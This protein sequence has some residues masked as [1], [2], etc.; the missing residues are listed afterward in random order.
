MRVLA[1]IHTMNDEAVIEQ[2]LEGL[3][4]QTRPSDA[5]LIV[6][7]ASTDKTLDRT[8]SETVTIVR[9]SENLGT[10]GTIRIGLAHALK[11]GFDWTWIFDADTVPES[12]SLEKLLAFF[13]GLSTTEQERVCF[14]TGWPLTAAGE[15]KQPAMR[16]EGPGLEFIPLESFRDFTQC[17]CMLWSGSLYRMAAVARIGLPSADYVLDI[18]EIEYGY[19]ARQLGFTSYIVHNNAIRHD[20]GR[21]P[22]APP[23]LYRFGPIRF[24]FHETPPIRTYYSVRNML[25]FWLY[26]HKPRRMTWPLRWVALRTALLSLNFV[27]RPRHYRAQILACFRGIWHGVTGNMAARY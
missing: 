4:G 26:Q 19:R 5:I 13:E 14:L 15:A 25:Y 8:F 27:A 16:L 11:N 17:D 2:A 9:N 20:V 18:A 7:N 21:V 6:D 22:G 3:R 10:S 1:H 12:D 23:R 24:T